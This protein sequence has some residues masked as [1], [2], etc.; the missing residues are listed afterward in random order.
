M[1]VY[2]RIVNQGVGDIDAL[3]SVIKEFASVHPTV[4]EIFTG[5]PAAGIV[6]AVMPGKITFWLEVSGMKCCCSP[7]EGDIS[8]F[9]AISEAMNPFGSLEAA[10]IGG[11]VDIRKSDK[12][13]AAY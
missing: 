2:S 11:T 10:L 1:S 9:A 13:K 3:K 8:I 5:A 4:G 12:R 7:K 6:P